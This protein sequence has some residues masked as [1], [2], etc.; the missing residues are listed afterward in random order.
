MRRDIAA[1]VLFLVLALGFSG[2]Y[3]AMMRI[4]PE[5]SLPRVLELSLWGLFRGFGPAVAALI[6]A[7]YKDQAIGIKRILHSLIR[8]KVE[9][10]WY[11]LGFLWPV[12]AVGAGIIAAH[13]VAHVSLRAAVGFTP[14]LVLVF[15]MMAIVDGPL[16]EEVGW[17]GFLLPELLRKMNPVLAGV[18]VGFIWWMWHIP[19]YLADGKSTP[20][21]LYLLNTTA[22]SLIFTWFF[23]R[24][25]ESTF[26]AIF[27]HNMSNYPIY[28]SRQIF[29]QVQGAM[30]GKIV[31][32][33][34]V[35]L[36][37]VAVVISLTL[38]QRFKGMLAS[39]YK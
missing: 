30:I 28:L 11:V 38:N 32:L 19:L 12:L 18:I 35:V 22:L 37:G 26:F 20:W 31:F 1:I 4:W 10:R 23:L 15:F 16:G 7:Y 13:F 24:T 9:P 14:R 17:R 5:G 39:S 33:A 25:K 36:L 34:I 27:L 2:C 6:A 21:L 29:P 3:W 8:W